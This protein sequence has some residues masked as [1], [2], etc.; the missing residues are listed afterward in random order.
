MTIIE[1]L[2]VLVCTALCVMLLQLVQRVR[3]L[4][5]QFAAR[6]P[7]QP[8]LSARDLQMLQNSLTQL[9]TEVEQYTESQLRKMR[10]QVQTA[11]DLCQQ[12]EQKLNT[13]V[14]PENS[15]EPEFQTPAIHSRVVPFSP[16]QSSASHKD[17][18][19]I[20]ELYNR[21]WDPEQIARELRITR[22]EVQLIVNLA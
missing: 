2:L 1:V 13:L 7:E 19:R 22:G 21:G 17:R 3:H 15:P 9:V 20:I 5:N 14:P 4:E 18:D 10:E 11:Q 8:T 12:I 16:R 6:P